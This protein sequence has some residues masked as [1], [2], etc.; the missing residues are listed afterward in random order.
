MPQLS[1][2][3]KVLWRCFVSAVGS[4]RSEESLWALRAQESRDFRYIV[5]F[6]V[7]R[8]KR[9]WLTSYS[10][11]NRMQVSTY[12]KLCSLRAPCADYTGT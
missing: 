5:D 11:V 12:E 2:P 3:S 6:P 8:A 10:C 1:R 9:V 4:E 7:P